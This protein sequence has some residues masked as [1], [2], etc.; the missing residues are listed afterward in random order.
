M[1]AVGIYGKD[2]HLGLLTGINFH[3]DL[4]PEEFELSSIEP[5]V[6]TNYRRHNMESMSCLYCD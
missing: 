1:R 3:V 5:E 6:F 4:H 2:M